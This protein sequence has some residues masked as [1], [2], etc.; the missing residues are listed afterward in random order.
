MT[1]SSSKVNITVRASIRK[2]CFSGYTTEIDRIGFVPG[3]EAV[4][5]LNTVQGKRNRTSLGA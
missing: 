2:S 3:K 1:L 5:G 4:F